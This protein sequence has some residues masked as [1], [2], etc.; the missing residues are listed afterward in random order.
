M[1]ISNSISGNSVLFGNGS[2]TFM[3]VGDTGANATTDTLT[4]VSNSYLGPTTISNAILSVATL[5]NGGVVSSIGSSQSAA[6]NLILDNGTLQYTGGGASTDRLFEISTNGGT[7]DSSGSNVVSFTNPGAIGFIGSGT[8]TLGLTG[9]YALSLFSPVIGDNGGATS[10][11]KSGTGG[12]ALGGINTYTGPTTVTG[13]TLYLLPNATSNNN[14]ANSS[15]LIAGDTAADSSATLDVGGI[16]GAGGFQVQSNQTLAGYGTVD[17]EGTVNVTM[18]SGSILSPANNNL[19]TLTI[20][21]NLTLNSGT[22]FTY[23]LDQIG[24]SG[25]VAV[26]GTLTLTQQLISDFTFTTGPDFGP[27]DYT[28]I[29]STSTILGSFTPSTGMVDG[30]MAELE[31][32]PSDMDLILD[33]SPVPEPDTWALFLAGGAVFLGL[34]AYQRRKVRLLGVRAAV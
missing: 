27:G 13:G 25:M 9:S 1:T 3:G 21:S 19:G 28:L 20:A 18:L 31:E 34:L 15:A 4:S 12:W 6:S 29:S 10:V 24:A 11:V 33:V 26:N 30:M 8:R 23:D 14:V 32:D 2:V 7:I 22:K 16:T 17:G 5:A